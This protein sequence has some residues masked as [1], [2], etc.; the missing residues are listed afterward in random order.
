MNLEGMGANA[1]MSL[2]AMMIWIILA[3]LFHAPPSSRVCETP[4]IRLDLRLDLFLEWTFLGWIIS[5]RDGVQ[6]CPPFR[7]VPRRVVLR[8]ARAD[9][10]HYTDNRDHARAFLSVLRRP[11][12]ARPM[13]S[14]AHN[15][16]VHFLQDVLRETDM[17]AMKGSAMSTIDRYGRAF[18]AFCR[19]LRRELSPELRGHI[20]VVNLF[21]MALPRS[22]R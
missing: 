10:G 4:T 1:R 21:A 8:H 16:A 5:A 18:D 19:T 9:P 20:Y 14:T 3:L 15:A 17:R 7:R 11:N 22:Q 2:T 6:S 12:G 13:R